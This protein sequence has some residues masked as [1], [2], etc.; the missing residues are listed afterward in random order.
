MIIASA[1]Y[2]KHNKGEIEYSE[3]LAAAASDASLLTEQNLKATFKAFDKS[4][5]GYITVS[6]LKAVFNEGREM[7]M[8][9]KRD[10]KALIH[11]ADRDGDGKLSFDEFVIMMTQQS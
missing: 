7:K 3:F 1:L 2:I 8:L 5:T 11:Q 10:A 6:D 9:R 4:N